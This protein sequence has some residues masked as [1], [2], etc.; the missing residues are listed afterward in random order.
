VFTARY[1]LSPY[2]KQ[3]RF[4]FKG[5]KD[6]HSRFFS[7]ES[8]RIKT[9]IIPVRLPEDIPLILTRIIQTQKRGHYRKTQID[10]L[11]EHG[12]FILN[13]KML[14]EFLI[15][16]ALNIPTS[17]TKCVYIM[18]HLSPTRSALNLHGKF[19]LTTYI[20]V[21]LEET[22][23]ILILRNSD[24]LCCALSLFHPTTATSLLSES[25]IT[26]PLQNDG[27]ETTMIIRNHPSWGTLN[28][29]RN[30]HS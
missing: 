6:L 18:H 25:C 5:L 26:I 2:I 27:S 1:A 23:C 17:S 10:T 16:I 3:I 29:F 7:S 14:T 22:S 4:V 15:G 13:K 11:M 12:S 28:R 21:H 19:L 24:H 8:R 20:Q 30:R 9:Q